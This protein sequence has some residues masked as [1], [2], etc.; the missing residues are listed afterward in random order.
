MAIVTQTDLFDIS[1]SYFNGEDQLIPFRGYSVEGMAPYVPEDH[2]AGWVCFEIDQPTGT[3]FQEA[4]CDLAS[5][6]YLDLGFTAE[7]VIK[8]ME[9]F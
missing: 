4:S 8:L 7:Q 3:T 6:L 9:D 1:I 5:R 2:R